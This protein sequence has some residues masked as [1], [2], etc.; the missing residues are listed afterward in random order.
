[1]LRLHPIFTCIPTTTCYINRYCSENV[2]TRS[3]VQYSKLFLFM[4]TFLRPNGIP[5]G[6]NISPC[7]YAINI[8]AVEC[9]QIK[10]TKC[11][12]KH[13]HHSGSSSC[14]VDWRTE[15]REVVWIWNMEL[16][17]LNTLKDR[18]KWRNSKRQKEEQCKS[19]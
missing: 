11:H 2:A 13:N 1:M 4:C 5:I 3:P 10:Q 6:P 19:V 9:I 8:P 15:T 12:N 16:L 17:M 14:W 18:R 7:P